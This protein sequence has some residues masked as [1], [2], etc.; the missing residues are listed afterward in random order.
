MFQEGHRLLAGVAKDFVL[1]GLANPERTNLV[2]DLI[3]RTGRAAKRACPLRPRLVLWLVITLS[4]YRN[5]SIIN[6]FEKIVAWAKKKE[7]RLFRGTVTPEAICHARKRLGVLPLK[8]FHRELVA[9]LRPSAPTFHGLR[10]KG[11]DGTVFTVPDTDKNDA[12]FGRQIGSRG[13]SA[14]PQLLGLFTV[15]VATHRIEDGIFVPYLTSERKALPYLLKSIQP[16]DLLLLDRG[17]S[18]FKTIYTC[19]RS[20]INFVF[21]ISSSWKPKFLRTLSNGDTLMR[22]KANRNSRTQLP[23]GERN[24]TFDLRVIK[25]RAGKKGKVVRLVTNLLDTDKYPAQEIAELYHERWECELTYKQ[26][27]SQLVAVTGSKQQ[28]HFRSKTPIG[29]LQEAWGMVLAH[30]LVRELMKEAAETTN[31][32]ARLMSFTDSLEVIKL[33]LRDFQGSGP[34]QRKI[35][36]QELIQ[37]LSKCVIDR[38][39]RKRQCPRVIKRKMSNFRLK[40]KGDREVPLDDQIHFLAS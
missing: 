11:I 23:K 35:L 8:Q 18:S 26:L 5:D 14:Y 24:T 28:T 39:R 12:V 13:R 22:F 15:D 27:K 30:T 16:G 9:S 32:P 21:R 40:R 25:Y 3:R 37:E 4:L 10:V 29:V 1:H 2:E 33:Y 19:A 6:V 31:V 7:P 38:P 17:L 34:R 36:R 20:G